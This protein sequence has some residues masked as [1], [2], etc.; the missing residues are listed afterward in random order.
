MR[1]AS[2]KHMSI[3]DRRYR[4]YR[5]HN[6]ALSV[7]IIRRARRQ[8]AGIYRCNLSGSTT[9]HKYK[10]LNVT[11]N[12]PVLRVQRAPANASP[13]LSCC[14]T[15]TAVNV[16]YYQWT[17]SLS[18]SLSLRFNRHFSGGPG[19]AG[20]RMSPFWILL[21]LRVTEVVVATS[22]WSYKT[23]KT[24]R[25]LK[26]QSNRYHQQTNTH[27]FTGWIPYY[28]SCRSTNTVKAPNGK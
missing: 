19:L 14:T 1:I 3:D 27:L 18:L 10:V 8:D 24:I 12:L 4:V 5:P 22:N 2:G 11:G 21:E 26:L 13:V 28:P 25:A 20:T 6:S 7:L 23:Y 15:V 9:R 17:L 16:E